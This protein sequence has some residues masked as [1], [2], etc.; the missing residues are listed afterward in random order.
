[1]RGED[2]AVLVRTEAEV[3]VGGCGCIVVVARGSP[4]RNRT[5]LNIVL[6][7]HCPAGRPAT[8]HALCPACQ[9]RQS[10]LSLAKAPSWVGLPKSAGV[11]DGEADICSQGTPSC[12][13]SEVY[14]LL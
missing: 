8:V 4:A 10:G 14:Q 3:G 13:V 1:M 6:V 2:G 5:L 7:Q 11:C 9:L 12:V